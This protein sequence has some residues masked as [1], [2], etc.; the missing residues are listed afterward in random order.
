MCGRLVRL[1][2][3]AIDEIKLMLS[4]QG[5]YERE[6]LDEAELRDIAFHMLPVANYAL[7]E[8]LVDNTRLGY[9][10]NGPSEYKDIFEALRDSLIEYLIAEMQEYLENN[11]E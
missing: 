5:G 3:Q 6:E 10:V 9:F 4:E 2:K 8:C 7:A 11:Y 1:Q